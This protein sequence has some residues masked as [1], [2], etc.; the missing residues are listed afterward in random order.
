M[1]FRRLL[2]GLALFL[3]SFTVTTRIREAW[4]SRTTAA[5]PAPPPARTELTA[6]RQGG[7]APLP[8][9]PVAPLDSV[10]RL[11]ARIRIS[12][13]PDRHY[14]DSLFGETDSI[15]RRWSLE[16][17]LL[18]VS[19]QP[20]GTPGFEPEMV[21]DAR[22]A[23]DTWSPAMVGVQ[24][25]EVADTA[26]AR[27]VI[28][29]SDTL[30]PD[31]AGLT[32]VIW[33]RAGRIHRAVVWLSTRSPATGR[34][35]APAVRRAVALH[36]LGHALGLPHS[37]RPEDVMHPIATQ[38]TPSG[39]DRFSLRLLYSLPTGWVGVEAAGPRR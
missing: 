29:W 33:D 39:R 23:I 20:G 28:R 6:T 4:E 16:S 30:G 35:L 36:E 12:A 8:A 32:D 3:L 14:L 22:W 7:R 5:A 37:A 25:H 21:T 24:L 38:T 27:L 34:P 26:E 19:I 11:T 31:R 1:M 9:G 18:P 17:G 2:L 15:I 10:A 13:E